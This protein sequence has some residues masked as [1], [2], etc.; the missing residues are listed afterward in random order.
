MPYESGHFHVF[1]HTYNDYHRLYKI[2]IMDSFC[3]VRAKTNIKAR[4]LKWKRRLPKNILSDCEIELIGF[5]TP[6]N[7]TLIRFAW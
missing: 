7:Y 6:P 2:H 3:V 5:F 1:D 4:V